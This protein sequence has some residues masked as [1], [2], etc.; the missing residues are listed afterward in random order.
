MPA[1]RQPLTHELADLGFAEP[2]TLTARI[3]AWSDGTYRALRS[4]EAREA[5][6]RMRPQLLEALARAPDPER[7]LLRCCGIP[8]HG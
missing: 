8:W 6:A 2:D 3:E 5:F 7:A 4:A 1:A